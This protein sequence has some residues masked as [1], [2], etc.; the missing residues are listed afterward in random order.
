MILA[1]NFMVNA[2]RGISIQTRIESD[3]VFNHTQFVNPTSTYGSSSI[4]L[5]GSAAAGRQS[6]LAL[7]VVF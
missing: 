3:N 6:Q 1:K 2:E 4:G 5:V 7:R